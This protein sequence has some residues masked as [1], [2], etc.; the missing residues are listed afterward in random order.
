M[1]AAITGSCGVGK[2]TLYEEVIKRFPD[3]F[4]YFDAIEEEKEHKT[5]KSMMPVHTQDTFFGY[6]RNQ[7]RILAEQM[8][9]LEW[10]DKHK[11]NIFSDGSL[12]DTLAYMIKGKESPYTYAL[13]GNAKSSRDIIEVL[14]P[15]IREAE[16]CFYEYDL[17]FYIPIEFKCGNPSKEEI[18][19]QWTIDNIIKHLLEV[20]GIRHHIV[21]G[22]VEE[23]KQFVIGMITEFQLISR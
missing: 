17:L 8:R 19:Y 5:H 9:Q 20:Y 2:T 21:G 18:L 14:S 6:M 1:K 10:V 13:S 22:S 15:I 16:S 23:R 7:E 3:T 11:I 4:F 12:I